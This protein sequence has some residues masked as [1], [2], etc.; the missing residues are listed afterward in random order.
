VSGFR[1]GMPTLIELP[2]AAANVDLAGRLGLSF[3]EL[4]M[5]LPAN[6]PAALPAAD[7]R[8]LTEQT[9]VGFTVH[10]PERLPLASPHER[11]RSGYLAFCIETIRWA[12]QAGIDL[13]NMHLN[14]GTYFSLPDRKVWVNER[15]AGGFG[16]RLEGAFAALLKPARAGGV[17]LCIENTG[18]WGLGFVREALERILAL[19]ETWIGLTWD[20]GH[21]AGG[22][23]QD[24]PILEQWEGRI[25][26]VHLH[27]FAAGRDHQVPFTGCVDIS[28]ALGLAKR[29]DIGVVI[30]TKT[31]DA[32]TESV[33]ALDPHKSAR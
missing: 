31:A 9:G 26:H 22:D 10:L 21:E 7:L 29:L 5:D 24:R 15:Y 2:D 20:T 18:A 8:R 25:A 6:A 16:D 23:F 19:D 1:L 13:V 17:K 12:A 14:R 32:L 28:A 33:K 30:E 11:I 3:V 27:D 4:N